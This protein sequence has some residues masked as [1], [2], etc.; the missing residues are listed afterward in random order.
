MVFV[1]YLWSFTLPLTFK[2]LMADEETYFYLFYGSQDLQGKR[3]VRIQVLLSLFGKLG[4]LKLLEF[5]LQLLSCCL[6][7][8][9]FSQN[10]DPNRRNDGTQA[11]NSSQ[12]SISPLFFW[13]WFLWTFS[14]PILP[15]DWRILPDASSSLRG[16][17]W[18][19]WASFLG[20]RFQL[21]IIFYKYIIYIY[22]IPI[23]LYSIY[24]L[25]MNKKCSAK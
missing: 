25:C 10:S 13:Q 7:W 2:M 1:F 11:L 3:I 14:V 9:M 23:F 22:D 18:L 16:L 12:L 15:S 6:T 21:K 19:C 4:N 8:Q 20:T 24:I 17:C 5:N